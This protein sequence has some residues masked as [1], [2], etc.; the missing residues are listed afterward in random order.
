MVSCLLNQEV[1][2]LDFSSLSVRATPEHTQ[3]LIMEE[4]NNVP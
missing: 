1:Q 3:D 4:K 2:G